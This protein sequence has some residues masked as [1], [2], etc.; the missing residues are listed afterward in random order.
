MVGHDQL[1]AIKNE[2]EDPFTGINFRNA[3]RMNNSQG[4]TSNNE[5]VN[6]ENYKIIHEGNG[7]IYEGEV[8]LSCEM[9]VKHGVGRLINQ[10]GT[11]YEGFWNYNNIEGICKIKYNSGDIYEGQFSNGKENGIGVK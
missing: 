6:M 4:G 3:L 2:Q 10:S 11:I 5:K 8:Q 9:F 7:D 1:S